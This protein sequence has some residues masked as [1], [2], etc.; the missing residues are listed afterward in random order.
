[1]TL[2]VQFLTLIAM[3]SSGFYLGII[4][5]TFRRFTPYWKNSTF[6]TYFLEISFWLTQTGIIF[7]VLFRVNA[8]ELRLY[9][10]LACFLGFSMYQVFAKSVYKI[11]LEWIIQI[12]SAIYRFFKSLFQ[13]LI[14]TPISWIIKLILRIIVSIITLLGSIILF[15]LKMVLTPFWW[16]AIGIYKVAPSTFKN[17][18]HKIA[19]FYSTMKNICY[20]Y[21]KYLKSKRR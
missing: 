3:V 1:M 6:L 18:L 17:F 14:I 19:G 8:G 15:I 7:Y 16:I 5:E 13:G 11:V 20:K 21:L 2:S 9:V 12:T 10:F 4:Q